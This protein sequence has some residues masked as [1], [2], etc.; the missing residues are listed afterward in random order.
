MKKLICALLI[1]AALIGIS[2]CK[3]NEPAGGENLSVAE[4]TLEETASLANSGTQAQENS[5]AASGTTPA[6]TE[7]GSLE[8]STAATS[9]QSG[10][11]AG[12]GTTAGDIA[13][14]N[15]A[16]LQVSTSAATQSTAAPKTTAAPANGILSSFSAEDL[17]GT[18]V[19]QDIF[20][21]K[22]LTMVNV[23]ATYC[24][25]CLREMPVLAEIHNDYVSRDF[26]IVGIVSDIYSSS[27][28]STAK[29][30]IT[31]TGVTY[32]NLLPSSSLGAIL[33]LAQYVPTTIFV[34]ENGVQ[35]GE[36][37]S[38]AKTKAAWTSIIDSLLETM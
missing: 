3:S 32:T 26:Q 8:T 16:T 23:W 17:N 18:A 34:D 22:K 12:Q 38:G 36:L 25:P 13:T 27:D 15:A 33:R 10:T 7:P 35:V 28:I 21:G 29:D 24:G 14:H 30:V 9:R 31:Q 20:K 1:P 5:S 19:T 11:T 2:A 37:Y 6:A 4:T